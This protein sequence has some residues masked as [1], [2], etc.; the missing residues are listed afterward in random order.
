MSV[1]VKPKIKRKRWRIGE[2]AIGGIITAEIS[3]DAPNE[4]MIIVRAEDIFDKGKIIKANYA[5]LYHSD[6]DWRIEST[7]C[8]WTTS[9]YADKVMQWIREQ[10]KQFCKQ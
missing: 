9:Y 2:Y 3:S 1:L 7:L 5:H 6:W 4:L 8:E 10:V